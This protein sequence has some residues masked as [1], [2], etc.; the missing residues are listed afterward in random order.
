MSPL[1]FALWY[2]LNASNR[3][4]IW[5]TSDTD[6]LVI[7]NRGCIPSFDSLAALY[8]YAQSCELMIQDEKP[9]LH[10]LDYLETWLATAAT[11]T[12]DCNHL[13]AAWNLFAD[14]SSS[15]AGDFDSDKHKTNACYQKL[16]GGSDTAND[17]L[18]PENEP[19]FIPQWS[20]ASTEMIH[21][22]LS[23]G[24]TMFKRMVQ[25]HHH[26]DT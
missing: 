4:L 18:R 12:V 20:K 3:Y 10:D 25:P 23:S 8:A 11:T 9:I 5:Y 6:G 19:I 26:A 15:V 2:R 13:L 21:K 22:I 7:N 17:V 14:I 24:L 1:Y 16:F